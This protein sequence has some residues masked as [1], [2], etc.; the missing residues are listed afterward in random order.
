MIT[1]FLLGYFLG[2]STYSL[3]T[4]LLTHKDERPDLGGFG[5]RQ[6]RN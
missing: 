2:I 3:V 6:P 4:Q 1:T 5:G